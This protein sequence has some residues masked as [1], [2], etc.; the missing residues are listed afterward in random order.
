MK[1]LTFV[2]T[3]TFADEIND[4]KKVM[5]VAQN[6]ANALSFEA[7]FGALAPES[8]ETFTEEIE[9]KP[10]FDIGKPITIKLQ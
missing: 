1:Q 4:N 2:V 9:V 3:L 7:E 10:W 8:G 6:I 5:E